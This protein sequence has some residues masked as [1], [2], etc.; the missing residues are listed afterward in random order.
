MRRIEVPSVNKHLLHPQSDSTLRPAAAAANT[1][2]VIYPVMKHVLVLLLLVGAFHE[3]ACEAASSAKFS[4]AVQ[5]IRAVG[6]EGQGNAQA[7]AAW[8][9]LAAADASA[10]PALLAA[11][12]GANELALNWL[13][14][15]VDSVASRELGASRKLP[16]A[17]LEKFVRDTKHHPRARRLAYEL[18]ARADTAKAASLIAGLQDDPSTELRRDAIQLPYAAAP[19]MAEPPG[20]GGTGAPRTAAGGFLADL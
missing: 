11:M 2:A 16:V 13:R 5:T 18:I 9:Q 6:P 14:A 4:D 17:A 20:P 15:A 19:S 3:K 10:L 7:T 8:K 1:K 12:D